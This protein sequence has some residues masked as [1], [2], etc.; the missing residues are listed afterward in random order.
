MVTGSKDSTV[1]R[2]SVCLPFFYDVPLYPPL[3]QRKNSSVF[4][5]EFK[6]PTERPFFKKSY[7]H[8]LI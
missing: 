1:C 4:E 8:Y 2:S 3:P 7:S 6:N 5:L